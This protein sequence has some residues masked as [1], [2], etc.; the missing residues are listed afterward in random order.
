MKVAIGQDSHRFDFENKNKQLILG[1]IVFKEHVSLLG[2]S[3][4]D[5]VLHAITNAISAML[6]P[7]VSEIQTLKEHST[8]YKLVRKTVI[9]CTFLG[10]ICCVIF[11]LS[12]DLA[13]QLLFDSSLAGRFIITLAWMCPFL[14]TNTTLISIINGTGRT[15]ISFLINTFSLSIRIFSVL[16][17]IPIYGIYG[18]LIGLLLSQLFTFIFSILFLSKQFN[19]KVL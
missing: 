2:N 17:L 10:S 5:V 4:A 12:G 14:Y 6:L 3:D 1:G 7:T 11:L 16:K 8:L 9:S 18:Y 15:I 13:G 19:A